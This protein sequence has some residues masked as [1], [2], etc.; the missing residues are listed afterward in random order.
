[1][2]M[3]AFSVP[4]AWREQGLP[5]Y[6]HHDPKNDM[7]SA[8]LAPSGG[9]PEQRAPPNDYCDL[10]HKVSGSPTLFRCRICGKTVSNRWHHA[11]IHRPQ[12]N[13]CPLCYQSFTRKDNMKAHIRIK[14]GTPLADVLSEARIDRGVAYL[15]GAFAHSQRV[16]VSD[17]VG[18]HI[19]FK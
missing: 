17:E 12:S 4:A 6:H 19:M 13:H 9:F 18:A 8:P 11:A 7:C 16:G 14:H 10:F 15:Q 3:V 1:M 2:V 5:P